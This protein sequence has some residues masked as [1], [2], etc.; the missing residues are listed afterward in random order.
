MIAQPERKRT[1]GPRGSLRKWVMLFSD[2]VGA[3]HDQKKT[4]ELSRKVKGFLSGGFKE[5]EE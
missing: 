5:I 1:L 3:K 4:D 2:S